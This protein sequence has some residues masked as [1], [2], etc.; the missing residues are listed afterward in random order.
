MFA[1]LSRKKRKTILSNGWTNCSIYLD[2]GRICL[3]IV[4]RPAPRIEPDEFE[5]FFNDLLDTTLKL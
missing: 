2:S 3:E 5:F 4:L 1:S